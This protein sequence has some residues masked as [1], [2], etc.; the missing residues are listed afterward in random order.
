MNNKKIRC[1]IE[2]HADFS[3][4]WDSDFEGSISTSKILHGMII[5]KYSSVPYFVYIL[6]KPLNNL[7]FLGEKEKQEILSCEEVSFAACSYRDISHQVER[8]AEHFGSVWKGVFRDRKTEEER[9]IE[10]KR[11]KILRDD[12]DIS[13]LIENLKSKGISHETLEYSG[14]VPVSS[15]YTRRIHILLS[16]EKETYI[17]QHWQGMNIL[18]TKEEQTKKII[19]DTVKS[20]GVVVSGA[21]RS[22]LEK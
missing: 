10:E 5:M 4:E 19:S 7:D 13:S 21:L 22:L 15:E 1:I 12:A 8:D 16:P 14:A 20:Y 17:S 18:R 11:L 6:S 2:P 3:L 9:K